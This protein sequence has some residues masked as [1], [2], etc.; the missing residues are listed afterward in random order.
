M[1]QIK[2][3]SKI[4]MNN[5]LVP[6]LILVFFPFPSKYVGYSISLYI[7]DIVFI[8]Y[9][10]FIF[11]KKKYVVTINN[12]T[13]FFLVFLGL[14][15]F[16]ILI[17]LLKG[18]ISS[19]RPFSEVLRTF[20]WMIIYLFCINY[21]KKDI[22]SITK[23]NSIVNKCVAIL[24][25]L[26]IPFITIELFDLSGKAIFRSLYEMNKSGNI[27]Q[28]YNRI[29]GPFR[30]PNFLGIWM[31]IILLYV[32]TQPYKWKTKILFSLECIGVIYFTGSRT[33]IL[34]SLIMLGLVLLSQGILDFGKGVLKKVLGVVVIA[35]VAYFVVQKQIDLFYSVRLRLDLNELQNLGGRTSIWEEYSNIMKENLLL[36]NGIVKSDDLV[37]DN[38]YLLYLYYYGIFGLLLY[39]LFFI[40]NIFKSVGAYL[41]NRKNAMLLYAVVLQGI[42]LV[43]GFTM[44]ILDALQLSFWYWLILAYI[45]SSE[46]NKMTS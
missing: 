4:E 44:Q 38:M 36:G 35:A 12:T 19:L 32:F 14:N 45:D 30:N 28:N 9:L 7:C 18:N 34:I 20:E 6:L 13:R 27:Y 43:S 11:V 33:A 26:L 2:Q 1:G 46:E 25:L 31:T 24:L 15:C 37:L 42:I 40:R 29:V 41:R 10:L 8:G 39:F 5:L 17:A 21:F 22:K 3:S 23:I 16:G